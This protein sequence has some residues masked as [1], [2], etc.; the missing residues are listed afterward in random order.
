MTT[1]VERQNRYAVPLDEKERLKIVRDSP[2]DVPVADILS[3]PLVCLKF[4]VDWRPHITGAI[5]TLQTWA[6]WNGAEDETNTGTQQILKLLE[7]DM[8][9]CGGSSEPCTIEILLADDEFFQEEYI[10]QVFG[11]YVSGQATKENELTT[12]YDGTPQSIGDLIPTAAPNVIE[13]NALCYAIN[14]FVSLYCSQKVCTIQAK[15]FLQVAWNE[16]QNAMNE[17][18]NLIENFMVVYNPNIFSCFVDDTEALTVLPDE[19]A[20]E[21]LG[22]FLYDE[23]SGVVMSQSNFDDALLAAAMTLTDNAQKIACVMNQDNAT[24]L[25]LHFLEAYNI[26]LGRQNAGDDIDCPCIPP[27]TYWMKIW[28]FSVGSLGWYSAVSSGQS[29]A[30]YMG[31]YWSNRTTNPPNSSTCAIAY[32][33]DRDYVIRACG[34]DCEAQ[35]MTGVAQ[36]TERAAGWSFAPPSG[37]ERFTGSSTGETS[38]GFYTKEYRRLTENLASASYQVAI[39][40]AGVPTGSNYSRIHRVVLY[41]LPN[42]G[43]KPPGSVW[44]S[45]VPAIPSPLF[46][47]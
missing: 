43:V 39:T 15:N 11:D 26:A 8:T 31:S 1:D 34:M 7:Q 47:V 3:D 6:A 14:K 27:D 10:P 46:P 19:S 5:E 22:C 29:V 9:D 44:V 18:Y 30:I 21:E 33:F 40:N 38:N 16:L 37:S 25:Y 2:R 24:L 45:D 20:Q 42:A 23:L 28:D 12:E 17:V 36:D 13:T 41:G 35:G 32:T 4:N